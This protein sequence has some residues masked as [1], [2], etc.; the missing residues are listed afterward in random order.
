[1]EVFNDTFSDRD[2]AHRFISA[3]IGEFYETNFP[4]VA[5][6]EQP[7]IRQATAGFIT[8]YSRNIFPEMKV[9][10][11]AYPNQ[12]G[13]VEF[14]GCFR[15][16]NGNHVSEDGRVIS[17]DC[18]LCHTIL[19]QGT[20]GH[21]ETTTIDRSLEF[22]HPVDIDEAWKELACADCHRHLY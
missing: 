16:H 15:C 11:D 17:R 13:H 12:T 8:G 10:W 2:S 4:E 14:N 22:R 18:N 9:S 21:F 1:M 5:D 19:G 6:Q 3:R 7:L 20:T